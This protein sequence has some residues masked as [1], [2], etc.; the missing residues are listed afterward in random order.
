MYTCQCERHQMGWGDGVLFKEVSAFRRCPLIEVSLYS[1]FPL[2][3]T[4]C[5]RECVFTYLQYTYAM[6]SAYFNLLVSIK[7]IICLVRMSF[8][9]TL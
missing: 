9:Q 5:M 2:C 1:S 6:L 4:I 3:V 7:Y 8:S